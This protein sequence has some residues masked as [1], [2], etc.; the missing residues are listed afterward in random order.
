VI[1]GSSRAS[2]A[3]SSSSSRRKGSPDSARE[4]ASSSSTPARGGSPPSA[5]VPEKKRT[6]REYTA[7]EILSTE[8]EYVRR[9]DIVVAG[10]EE[11]K[12][13]DPPILVWLGVCGCVCVFVVVVVCVCVCVCVCR[14]LYCVYVVCM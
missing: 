4:I 11:L 2:D 3:L 12:A 1:T 7:A 6:Q 10:I 9:L 5:R 8:Q 14:C 13:S